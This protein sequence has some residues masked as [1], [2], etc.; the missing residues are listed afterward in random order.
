[1]SKT[2]KPIDPL[3]M[4]G[5]FPAESKNAQPVVEGRSIE[6]KPIQKPAAAPSGSGGK[7]EYAK[8]TMDGTSV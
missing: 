6:S 5:H 4:A 7:K 1:M 3:E 8:W 2:P